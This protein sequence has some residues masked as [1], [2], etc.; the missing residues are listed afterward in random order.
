MVIDEYQ[1]FLFNFELTRGYM[2]GRIILPLPPDQLIDLRL[3][4]MTPPSTSSGAA[5]KMFSSRPSVKDAI[6]S[7]ETT[8]IAWV[9]L[10]KFALKN[11]GDFT[12]SQQGPHRK[13]VQAEELSLPMSEVA[14]HEQRLDILQSLVS[15]LASE[16]IQA[17]LKQLEV[18]KSQY[19]PSFRGLEEEL[20][21]ALR[22]AE[23]V[24]VFVRCLKPWFVKLDDT[25]TLTD[26]IMKSFAPTLH[27]MFL[28]WSQK[29]YLS[30]E[31]NL[32]RLLRLL[33]NQVVLQAQQRIS[34]RSLA[35]FQESLTQELRECLRLCAAFRGSYLDYM[36][37][38]E[39]ATKKVSLSV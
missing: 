22:A 12:S 37:K 23:Q 21:S 19:I 27:I 8:L 4:T 15:Q 24:A 30:Q 25:A 33:C 20:V 3:P 32:K 14:L 28:I 34:E 7:L 35:E 29:Q 2:G 31:K 16:P 18:H 10:I 13:K 26:Q 9:R 36:H 38:A 11:D 5:S 39:A 17:V 1:K 6:H